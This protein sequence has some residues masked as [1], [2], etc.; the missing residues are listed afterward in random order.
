[1]NR[2]LLWVV[3]LTLVYALALASFDPLD[4]LLGA[5]LAAGLLTAL[6]GILFGGRPAAIAGLGRRALAAPRLAWAVARD[7]T[8]GT[9][10]VAL[11][12]LGVRPLVRPGI[13]A[14][15]FGDRSPNGAIV[16]GF[17]ATLAPGEFLVEID[18]SSERLLLHVLDARDPD[19][20][21]ARF[22]DFY[23]RYQRT[24]AP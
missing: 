12:T 8:I 16:T 10:Q 4:L 7:I 24:F 15:P 3:V 13:V 22:A 14:V 9:W 6:R 5:L 20:V 1:M 2:A 17:V 18:W 21:R 23:R 19:A 11:V